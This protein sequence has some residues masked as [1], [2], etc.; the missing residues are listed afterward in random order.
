MKWMITGANGNLGKRLLQNLLLTADTE[1]VAL[2]RSARAKGQIEDLLLEPE[3]RSR[4]EVV[5]AD[6]TSKQDLQV[7]SEG[8]NYCVHLVGIL[9]ETPDSSYEKAHEDSCHALTEALQGGSVSHISYVSI[10]GALESATN[11]CLK[12]KSIAGDTL[13]NS[14]TK[15]MVLRVPMVLGE[16]DYASYALRRN[17]VNSLNLLFRPSSMDQPLYAGDVIRAIKAAASKELDGSYD[18]VGP[19]P[20]S[21]RDLIKRAASVLGRR[22]QVI[23]L[24]IALGLFLAGLLEKLSSNPPLTRSMLEVLDHDD[25][26][27]TTRTEELLQ[28][29]PLVSV[30]TMLERVLSP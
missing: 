9:K 21:R 6:Y 28:I 19:E 24:P 4:L 2:V 5:I 7:A 14:T 27:D 15:A 3:Q 22:T 16:G 12:S 23:G 25:D 13:L 8:V 30:D 20:L 26:M 29:S 10:V 11:H 17:A 18:L 1:V